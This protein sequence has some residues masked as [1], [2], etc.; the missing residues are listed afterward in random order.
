MRKEHAPKHVMVVVGQQVLREEI[1]GDEDLQ[2]GEDGAVTE[3]LGR[4]GVVLDLLELGDHSE[5]LREQSTA[6]YTVGWG[7]EGGMLQ[8]MLQ[9]L[10]QGMLWETLARN[11]KP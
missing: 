9:G 1:L 3:H 7:V 2:A 8:G 5:A 4:G 10:L 11:Q 6:C